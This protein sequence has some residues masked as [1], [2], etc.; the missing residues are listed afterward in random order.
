MRNVLSGGLRKKNKVR[1]NP[2]DKSAARWAG[3]KFLPRG[4][5]K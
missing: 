2:G 1:S 5:L 3:Q 4:K